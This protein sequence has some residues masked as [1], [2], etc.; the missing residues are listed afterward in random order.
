MNVAVL[1]SPLQIFNFIEYLHRVARSSGQLEWTVIIKKGYL[2]G[3]G[4]IYDRLIEE[5]GCKAYFFRG[6][7]SQQKGLNKI[8]RRVFFALKFKRKIDGILGNS[9]NI[10]KLVLGDYRS[11]ECRHIMALCPNVKVTLIDDGSATHQIAKYLALPKPLSISPMF[12]RMDLHALVLRLGGVRLSTGAPA[13]LFT[14]YVSS[15]DKSTEVIPHQY[16]YW[17]SQLKVRNY[18][19]SKDILF[20]GMSHVESGITLEADYMEALRLILDF[21]RG[22]RVFYKPHRKESARKLDRISTLGYEV[23]AVEITPVEYKLIHGEDL[24]LEVASIAS[25]ALDNIPM[26]FGR[27][28]SCRCFVPDKGYCVGEMRAHFCDI[29]SYHQR[30]SSRLGLEVSYLKSSYQS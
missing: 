25:S 29:I 12:P 18:E 7:P 10:R 9:V 17:R 15:V 19:Y 11:R 14:H 3:L 27:R 2:I 6:L 30:F 4:P 5:P 23:L 8:F 20:L 24:P 26:L 1:T 13:V 22:R 28:L 21:Y 16:V